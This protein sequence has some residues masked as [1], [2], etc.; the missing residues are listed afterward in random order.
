MMETHLLPPFCPPQS[1]TAELNELL[2]LCLHTSRTGRFCRRRGSVVLI[3]F[4]SQ[5]SD[6]TLDICL[7]V[8]IRL[9][10]RKY[11]RAGLGGVVTRVFWSGCWT[12]SRRSANTL[13]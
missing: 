8:I 1:L 3:Y 13:S 4:L 7:I 5:G 12:S 9:W 11:A 10:K 2:V 6:L